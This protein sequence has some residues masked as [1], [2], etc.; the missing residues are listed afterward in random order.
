MVISVTLF[1]LFTTAYMSCSHPMKL[2]YARLASGMF[3]SFLFWCEIVQNCYNS[4][5]NYYFLFFFTW[6]FFP[7]LPWPFKHNTNKKRVFLKKRLKVVNPAFVFRFLPSELPKILLWPKTV[8]LISRLQYSMQHSCV[9]LFKFA[10]VWHQHLHK[11]LTLTPVHIKT[12]ASEKS[13]RLMG[14]R[15][16]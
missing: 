13:S 2:S 9:L 8:G 3:V 11:Q 6:W 4:K 7:Q 14:G 15:N 16:C 1:R 5:E 12:E 10:A